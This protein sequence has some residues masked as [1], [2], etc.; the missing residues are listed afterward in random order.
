MS[1][2]FGPVPSRRLGISL[3]VD[4][5]PSKFCSYDC[6]YCQ[7]GR[8]T[9]N[10]ISRDEY[11]SYAAVC[12][13]IEEYFSMNGP[14]VDHI[15]FSGSGEP[16][17]NSKIGHIITKIK[18]FTKI[19]VAVLTNGSLLSQA[20]VQEN[21]MAA[22]IVLPSL[23][24]ATPRV[25]DVVNRPHR[26]IKISE[27]ISGLVSFKKFF[28][29]ETW[30]EVLLCR[31]INDD[32]EELKMIGRAINEIKPNKVHLNTVVRPSCSGLA[33]PL[34]REQLKEAQRILGKN[35]EI[36]GDFT[37][38]AFHD[39]HQNMEEKILDLLRRRPS[40]GTELSDVLGTHPNEISKCIDDLI[41]LKKVSFVVHRN[42]VYYQSS[43]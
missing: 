34:S 31:G 4:I 37:E 12:Q 15:T 23:D 39:N 2:L 5:V 8:T 40:T 26:S 30:L 19:P 29:G 24:A 38:P 42:N 28:E 13:D 25:F 10:T 14:A 11:V 6:I 20:E 32:K 35:T 22:D 9:N 7:L 3:G 36:I 41:N 33:Y 1:C 16:T 27:V 17:S 43:E 18:E 21:L